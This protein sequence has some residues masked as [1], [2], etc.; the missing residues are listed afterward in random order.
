MKS[1]T[2]TITEDMIRD[3]FDFDIGDFEED[4]SIKFESDEQRDEFLEDCVEQVIDKYEDYGILEYS[5][6]YE[7]IIYDTAKLYGILID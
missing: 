2:V 4:G 5:P 7:D 3:K 6:N 1:F